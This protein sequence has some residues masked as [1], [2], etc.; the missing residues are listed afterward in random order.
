MSN[1]SEAVASS[2]SEVDELLEEESSFWGSVWGAASRI[3]QKIQKSVDGIIAPVEAPSPTGREDQPPAE[4]PPV[5]EHV[6]G[7]DDVIE[8]DA[9]ESKKTGLFSYFANSDEF[10]FVSKLASQVASDAMKV[11]NSD[12]SALAGPTTETESFDNLNDALRSADQAAPVPEAM[13]DTPTNAGDS[14]DGGFSMSELNSTLD[15]GAKE[16][17]EETGSFDSNF[18]KQGGID[19]LE[20]FGELNS[21]LE[22]TVVD[23]SVIKKLRIPQDALDLSVNTELLEKLPFRIQDHQGVAENVVSAMRFLF[24]FAEN[25]SSTKKVPEWFREVK[26]CFAV[27][28]SEEFSTPPDS[29]RD[30]NLDLVLQDA[31]HL[32]LFVE[33]VIQQIESVIRSRKLDVSLSGEIRSIFSDCVE[34]FAALFTQIER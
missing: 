23:P 28:Y 4:N 29:P 10:R 14:M 15:V 11:L 30:L 25:L 17:D 33:F 32:Q 22:G 26:L 8:S 2:S 9:D 24:E 12:I 18:R 19:L 5:Q 16:R 6:L 31:V 34:P 21:A 7:S 1:V 27:S 20:K 13:E 3:T